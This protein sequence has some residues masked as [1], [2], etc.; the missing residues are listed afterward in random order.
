[1]VYCD[2]CNDGFVVVAM[3]IWWGSVYCCS[4]VVITLLEWCSACGGSHD[5]DAVGMMIW[6]CWDG[7]L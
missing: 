7:M 4:V 3:V 1:M 6:G 5:G 2:G